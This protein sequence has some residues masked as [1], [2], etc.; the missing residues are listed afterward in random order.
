M[1]T[2]DKNSGT[3]NPPKAPSSPGNP[4][5]NGMGKVSIANTPSGVAPQTSPGRSGTNSPFGTNPGL[6]NPQRAASGG[7]D[8]ANTC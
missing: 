4:E 2:I 7:A 8:R 3:S 6:S 5:S 1:T